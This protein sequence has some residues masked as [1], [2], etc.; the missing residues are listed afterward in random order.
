LPPLHSTHSPSF[1]PFRVVRS[2]LPHPTKPMCCC[3]GCCVNKEPISKRNPPPNPA[4]E[5]KSAKESAITQQ[6]GVSK[7]KPAGS[8]E[9][10]TKKDSDGA[11]YENVSIMK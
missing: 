3:C 10:K 1:P 6:P 4:E 9:Q 5:G 8:M 11:N 2:S 7:A